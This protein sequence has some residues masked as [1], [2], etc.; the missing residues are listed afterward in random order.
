[1]ACGSLG[2]QLAISFGV[3]S[4]GSWTAQ[5]Y[6]DAAP[7][8]L[9]ICLVVFAGAVLLGRRWFYPE[10]P[11]IETISEH[12]TDKKKSF[13]TRIRLPRTKMF[14]RLLWQTW[15]ESWK[16]MLVGILL[17]FVIFILLMIP[18]DF[19]PGIRSYWMLLMSLVPVAI[20]GALV[21]R[22]DQQRKDRLFAATHAIPPRRMWFAR[23]AVWLTL[24]VVLGLGIN[25]LASWGMRQEVRTSLRHYLLDEWGY[26]DLLGR[27][28][29]NYDSP[30][31]QWWR[32]ERASELFQQ[33]VLGAW[34]AVIAAYG[35]GQLCSMLLRQSLLAGFLAI[36]FSIAIAGWSL[37]VFLWQLSPLI[38]VLPIGIAT[39]FATWLRVPSWVI[40]RYHFKHWLV[41][42]AF[43]I[44]PLALLVPTIPDVRSRQLEIPEPVYPFLKEPFTQIASNFNAQSEESAKLNDELNQ[45]FAEIQW[46]RFADVMIEDPSLM[47]LG[48]T[49]QKFEAYQH[50]KGEGMFEDDLKLM[51]R[52][53][54]AQDSLCAKRNQE[55]IKKLMTLAEHPLLSQVFH[56]HSGSL[57]DLLK[58]D[59]M[60]LT[61]DDDLATTWERLKA[62]ARFD[63]ASL[64]LNDSPYQVAILT[65]AQHPDQ[66]SEQIKSAIA[67][68]Q[69]IFQSLPLP[70]ERI[71]RNYSRSRSM[72]LEI[73]PPYEWTS[74]LLILSN[75]LP[76]EQQRG[77]IALDRLTAQSL[78]YASAVVYLARGGTAR[79]G[80]NAEA[81]DNPRELIR[82]APYSELYA[83]HPIAFNGQWAYFLLANRVAEASA[84]SFF[85][86]DMW[87][88]SGNLE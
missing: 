5:A 64:G 31:T 68:L 71:L 3:N 57:S 22:S 42:A 88:Y 18:G 19:V 66:T 44:V 32:F 80:G 39:L 63:D 46:P 69:Q 48:I 6:A 25:T 21:F 14:S 27:E 36:L 79:S 2:A 73:E 55:V 26:T 15:R 54:A 85:A 65:W 13:T 4:Q 49:E 10:V 28:F 7:A 52:F 74:P 81:V 87:N 51:K 34:C 23:Q 8:R 59:A 37:L 76:G 58:D 16:S 56:Q 45:L 20:L 29:T 83:I 67:D 60:R 50:A 86:A 84:T 24:I 30:W 41:P 78:N 17:G 47:E 38:Y 72:V 70:S 9:L 43:V 1:M 75:R 77:L 82:M 35:V 61:A 11:S 33:G 62:Q 40:G 53:E 12:I